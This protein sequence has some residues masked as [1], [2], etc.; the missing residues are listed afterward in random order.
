MT[1]VRYETKATEEPGCLWG[2]TMTT[3]RYETKAAEEIGDRYSLRQGKQ[4]Y[5]LV[6]QTRH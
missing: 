5:T 6:G 4:G 1:T 3:V 2:T